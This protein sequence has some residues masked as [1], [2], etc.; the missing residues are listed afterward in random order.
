MILKLQD[1]KQGEAVIVAVTGRLEGTAAPEIEKHCITL[2]RGGT[3]RLLLDLA[4]VDYIS[5]AGLRS[6]LVIAKTIKATKGLLVLCNLSPMVRD[7]M[8]ISCFDKILTLAA[9]RDVALAALLAG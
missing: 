5:S 1:E 7:V 4:G 8:A 2:I 9:N 6:L 3:T